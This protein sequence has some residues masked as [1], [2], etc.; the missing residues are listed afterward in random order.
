[1]EYNTDCYP[2]TQCLMSVH[3]DDAMDVRYASWPPCFQNVKHISH[4]LQIK[5]KKTKGVG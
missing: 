4:A 5:T 2:I 3:F 1:M